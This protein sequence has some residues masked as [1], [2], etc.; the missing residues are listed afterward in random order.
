MVARVTI[1]TFWV[2]SK[3]NNYNQIAPLLRPMLGGIPKPLRIFGEGIPGNV[4]WYS[5]LSPARAPSLE[6]RQRK[7]PLSLQGGVFF[8]GCNANAATHEIC[9]R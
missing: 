8:K 6:S 1:Q 5:Y 4:I 7:L 9:L 2:D 3:L